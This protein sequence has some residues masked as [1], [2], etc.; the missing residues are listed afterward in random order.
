MDRW[1]ET[2]AFGD[3]EGRA[4]G[5]GPGDAADDLLSDPA[6]DPASDRALDAYSRTVAT[7]ADAV[8]PSVVRVESGGGGRDGTGSG[9]V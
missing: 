8:G 7:V 3:L 1:V 6:S 2:L 9:V 5:V 4:F